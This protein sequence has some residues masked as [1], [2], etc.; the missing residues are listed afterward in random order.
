M[1]IMYYDLPHQMGVV[2]GIFKFG[3]DY[4]LMVIFDILN[5]AKHFTDPD[6]LIIISADD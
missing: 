2:T 4:F 5:V 1:K 6:I 3:Q